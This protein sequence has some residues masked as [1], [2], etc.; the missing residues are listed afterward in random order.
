MDF[1]SVV[2]PHL[3]FVGRRFGLVEENDERG[4]PRGTV[5]RGGRAGG[6]KAGRGGRGE[7][8]RRT[9]LVEGRRRLADPE[10]RGGSGVID[11]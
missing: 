11:G 1:S 8:R 2:R 10:A 6:G 5:R 4:G 3:V 9:P 7:V